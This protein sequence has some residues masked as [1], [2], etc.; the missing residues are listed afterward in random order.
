MQKATNIVW[1]H[2]EITKKRRHRLNGHRSAVL[3]FTGLSGAGKSTVANALERRLHHLQM[4]T[5]LLDGDNVRH[6]LN[7][8]L[9]FGDADRTENIRR[10]GEVSKLFVDAGVMVLTAF[11]S[12]FRSDRNLVRDLVDEPEFIE[13]YVRCPL[14][15]C[16]HRDVKG[17]YRRARAGEIPNFTGIDSPYEEPER[18]EIVIDTSELTLDE[19]VDAILAYLMQQGYIDTRLQEAGA[20]AGLIG[21]FAAQRA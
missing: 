2:S 11:I 12:P 21:S 6:G 20:A 1:S 19:C 7:K 18:P 9:G 15:V 14:S 3:W 16:E 10:I 8:D 13:V 4:R 5:Y 17:L